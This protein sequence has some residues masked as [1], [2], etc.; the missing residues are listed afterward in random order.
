MFIYGV[1]FIVLY[2]DMDEFDCLYIFNV[3]L[4]MFM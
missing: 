2:R 1:V 3:L 4:D